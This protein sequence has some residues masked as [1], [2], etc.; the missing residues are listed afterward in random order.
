MKMKVD[1][2]PRRKSGE[3]KSTAGGLRE[4]QMKKA[5][6]THRQE[7]RKAR[8]ERASREGSLPGCPR[9]VMVA[10]ACNPSTLRGRGKKITSFSSVK[11]L[12]DLVRC[13]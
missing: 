3:R 9:G 8:K 12:N 7:A 5:Q 10:H 13:S 1:G 4:E 2:K 11:Q 6:G